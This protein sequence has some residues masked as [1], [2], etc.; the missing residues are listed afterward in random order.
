MLCRSL[1]LKFYSQMYGHIQ[2]TCIWFNDVS[3]QNS[4]SI[5]RCTLRLLCS[6]NCVRSYILHLFFICKFKVF[7]FS[8]GA[9]RRLSANN[10]RSGQLAAGP[11]PQCHHFYPQGNWSDWL[12]SAGG[13]RIQE[14]QSKFITE[15]L[16]SKSIFLLH[17]SAFLFFCFLLCN[18]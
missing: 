9:F 13:R 17:F 7:F 11:S 3:N 1:W 6:K 8:H 5:H 4:T 2:C 10:K 12:S 15:L 18:L 14:I 16:C